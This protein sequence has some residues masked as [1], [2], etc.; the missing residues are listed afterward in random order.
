MFTKSMRVESLALVLLSLC[1]QTAVAQTCA[2]PNCYNGEF[3][4][5]DVV[6]LT[7][8]TVGPGTLSALGDGPSI[9]E[10]G[11]VAFSAQIESGGAAAGSGIFLW[12]PTNSVNPTYVTTGYLN[13]NRRFY[14]YLQL[15]DQEQI[16]V[17]DE[18]N[19]S[20]PADLLRI[21]QGNNPGNFTL[22][23]ESGFKGDPFSLVYGPAGL[24]ASGNIVF[25][26][27]NL[28]DDS[29]LA[30]PDSADNPPFNELLMA[31]PVSPMIDDTGDVV[32][33]QGNTDQ[34]PIVLLTNNLNSTTAITVASSAQFSA[35][36]Q[37][38]GISRDGFAVAFAGNMNAAGAK[39]W[40]TNAGPG[41]FVA[42]FQNGSVYQI[43][44]VAGFK[45][46][47]GGI[48]TRLMSLFPGTNNRE[49]GLPWCVSKSN[50]VPGGELEDLPPVTSPVPAY[51]ATFTPTGFKGSP[52]WESRI[53]VTHVSELD[54][55]TVIV[56]FLATPNVDD[57]A[58][59]G[60]FSETSGVW[61]VR[62]DLFDGGS[63]GFVTHVY[64]P[65]PVVQIGN[66][67][68]IDG[69][70]VIEVSVYD[71][72]ANE[73]YSDSGP[74]RN[75]SLGD[76]R[77]ALWISTSS[78]AQAILR[79]TYIQQLGGSGANSSVSCKKSYAGTLGSL[80]SIGGANYV[81]SN[82]HVFGDPLSATENGAAIGNVISSPG[83][84]DYNSQAA[85]GVA[86]FWFA[87]LLNTEIDAALGAVDSDALNTTGDIYNVGIPS[88]T[89]A[90]PNMSNVAKQGRTTMVEITPETVHRF[91]F[92]NEDLRCEN[93]MGQ[94][95]YCGSERRGFVKWTGSKLGPQARKNRMNS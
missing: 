21:W 29:L 77:I 5:F 61:T 34:S 36:G 87:P 40:K 52:E 12:S 11:E 41:V 17:L 62:A 70:T 59:L 47:T 69:S 88:A 51:F 43:V 58:G 20:P 57:S 22:V 64:R 78:N 27:A 30:T 74:M 60:L 76:H 19:G 46:S 90:S 15:N 38:P 80:V 4:R 72:A 32:V 26:A 79:G 14:P 8:Q 1:L 13:T 66:M 68:P 24:N 39:Q 71:Q 94:F 67:F 89:V 85:P 84:L 49:E 44:R 92:Q 18:V 75:Q 28:S 93:A 83:T 37:S 56:S 7:G 73:V 54:G 81:L 25:S 35:L 95:I 65:I 16:A 48:G 10:K 2:L 3:Y 55:D 86:T 33:R 23:A 9:N 42:I 91:D 50:C 45:T 63:T 53:A 31:S 6:G 82:D